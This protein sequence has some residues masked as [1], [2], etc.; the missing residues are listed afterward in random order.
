MPTESSSTLQSRLLR[1]LLIVA[2]GAIAVAGCR[3]GAMEY[4]AEAYSVWCSA[5]PLAHPAGMPVWMAAYAW[6]AVFGHTLTSLRLLVATSILLAAAIGALYYRRRTGRRT[7]A[8]ALFFISVTGAVAG[9]PVTFSWLTGAYP[10]LTLTVI[11][12]LEWYRTRPRAGASAT[13][14]VA[15]G[16]LSAWCL[17]GGL[18]GMDWSTMADTLAETFVTYPAVCFDQNMYWAPVALA[19]CLS[20][21][22][23]RLYP[24]YRRKALWPIAITTVLFATF[25]G[26]EMM[27]NYYLE[28]N[29]RGAL[30][31]LVLMLLLLLPLRNLFVAR[32]PAG[33]VA[34]PAAALWLTALLLLLVPAGSAAADTFA[35]APVFFALAPL[36][37][38]LSPL[39]TPGMRRFVKASLVL[40][41]LS[42]TCICGVR[43]AFMAKN[44]RMPLD[45]IPMHRGRLT[46]QWEYETITAQFDAAR[47]FHASGRHFLVPAGHN[48]LRVLT[49][50]PFPDRETV[51]VTRPARL[52]DADG[53]VATALPQIDTADAVIFEGND[54]LHEWTVPRMMT[55]HGFTC[56]TNLR[57]SSIWLRG[58]Q[59]TDSIH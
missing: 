13:L 27:S 50:I 51:T 19:L 29:M 31:P 40:T 42:V 53:I 57:H 45:E 23:S 8:A 34:T 38:L 32:T 37:A 7:A 28:R 17:S 49:D 3:F 26:H 16:A 20:F 5:D 55:A 22:Y 46:H 18:A 25:I 59:T 24:G 30:Q 21:A 58:E 2:A 33:R 48:R 47:T 4:S 56:R 41:A 6:M 9:A 36:C 12:I 1:L 35:N 14:A 39:L 43:L 10:A 15:A 52:R 44:Y 11:F 54:N